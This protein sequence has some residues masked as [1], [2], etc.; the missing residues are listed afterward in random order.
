[1]IGSLS[2]GNQQKVVIGKMLAT[3]PSVV[4]LDEPIRGIDIGAKAEV[5]RLL[6]E[7]AQARPRRR[8]LDLRGRRVPVRSPTAS[9]SWPRAR[10]PPS[11]APTSPR[12]RSWPP[13]ARS[14]S[15]TSSPTP[16]ASTSARSSPT[17]TR[18][19]CR[20]EALGVAGAEV[21][22]RRDRP[23][24]PMLIGV[25]YGRTL[26][27]AVD[28][29][30]ETAGPAP[31]LRR[32]DG[33]PH[34]RAPAPTRT[35][36]STA[37]AERTGA[38]AHAH[39]GAVHGQHRRRP[40]R[41]ARPARTSPR[42]SRSPAGCDLMLVGI[43]TTV[44]EASLVSTGM[45]EPAEMT[46]DP[47]RRRRRRDARPLLRRR[48]AAR[49]RPTSTRR[50]VTQP[51]ERAARPPHRRRRRRRR[52]RS[53]PSAPSSRAASSPASSPTSAPP[54]PSPTPPPRRRPRR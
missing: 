44:D 48:R 45:I 27:A 12:R 11:S 25:G 38:E 43:G 22:R 51:L 53:T 41:A 42:P 21:P 33:R 8:L 13:P 30:P 40:R 54:A 34:P 3:N 50:I 15:S 23:G 46:A 29:L 4:L 17:S 14:T 2:G 39:A 19:S 49:S 31:P 7:G 9:S 10:S 6:A 35:R 20:C 36:S 16:T 1:M 52:S 26:A 28:G 24:E 5:F 32:A 37:L 18:T 47:P